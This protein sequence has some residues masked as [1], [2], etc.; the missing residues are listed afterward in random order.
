MGREEYSQNSMELL[1]QMNNFQQQDQLHHYCIPRRLPQE[2][3][4]NFA[5]AANNTTPPL[6]EE[7]VQ[8]FIDREHLSS[9]QTGACLHNRKKK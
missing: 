2:E 9:V 1:S 7:G 4:L 8:M 6:E 5:Q 3:A